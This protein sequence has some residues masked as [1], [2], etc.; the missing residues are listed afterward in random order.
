VEAHGAALPELNR[1][2]DQAKAAPLFWSRDVRAV[3]KVGLK[4]SHAHVELI[5]S[6]DRLRLIARNG[7]KPSPVGSSI[8][9]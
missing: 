5:A 2:G 9:V 7:R 4:S 8:K 3:G 1:G 6:V